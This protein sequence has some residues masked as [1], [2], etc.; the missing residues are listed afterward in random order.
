MCIRD[1]ARKEDNLFKFVFHQVIEDEDNGLAFAP[2][3]QTRYA[4]FVTKNEMY[5]DIVARCG[6]ILGDDYGR[7]GGAFNE[8]NNFYRQHDFKCVVRTDGLCHTE[9]DLDDQ[10][11]KSSIHYYATIL[12]QIYDPQTGEV[13]SVGYSTVDFS[14][15]YVSRRLHNYFMIGVVIVVSLVIA[16]ALIIRKY[17]R[18]KRKLMYEMQDVRNIAQINN[19]DDI[20]MRD[21]R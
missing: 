21:R 16:L 1:R 3:V 13:F 18:L 17:R 19:P 7:L 4:L 6:N 11:A 14:T 5:L 2:Q 9:I 20:E 8:M 12:A 15:A 10:Y